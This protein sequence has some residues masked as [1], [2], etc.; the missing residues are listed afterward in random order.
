MQVLKLNITYSTG[1]MG[2][3]GDVGPRGES[4]RKGFKGTMGDVGYKGDPGLNGTKGMNGHKGEPGMKGEIGV[5]G[6]K[7]PPAPKGQSGGKQVRFCYKPLWVTFHS[8]K[9]IQMYIYDTYDD[10]MESCNES[11][12]PPTDGCLAF[13]RNTRFIYIQIPGDDCDWQ[14]WVSSCL[15]TIQRAP[16]A[17][18]I[19]IYFRLNVC[20][21]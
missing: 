7:G 5:S 20:K 15:G 12:I 1:N 8:E 2:L 14:P 17:C 16:P 11:V 10:L 13:V 19:S 18:V 9:L 3:V 4:G 6:R 21:L